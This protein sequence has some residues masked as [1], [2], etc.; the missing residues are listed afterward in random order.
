MIKRAGLK[1]KLIYV[2]SERAMGG[3]R[4]SIQ[5]REKGLSKRE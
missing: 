5:R 2:I 4:N 1:L 3:N